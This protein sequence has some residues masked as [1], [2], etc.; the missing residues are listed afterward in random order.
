MI[1]ETIIITGAGRGIGKAIALDLAK[2]GSFIVCISRTKTCKDTTDEILKNG[3]KSEAIILDVSD[4]E[5]TEKIVQEYLNKTNHNNI[6]LVLA[7]GIIGPIGPINDINLSEWDSCHRVNVL[8]SLAII[9][10]CL[11]MML[12]DK[13]GK[14][15]TFAGGGAAYANPVFPAYSA[16][17]TAMVRITENI[18]EDLKDKGDFSIICLGPGAIETDMLKQVKSAGGKIKTLSHISE[19]I[20]LVR[21]FMES[22]KCN[23]SGC[24][25]HVRNNWKDYLDSDKKISDSFW[26]LRRIE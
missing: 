18:N 5:Y 9:K 6:G 7:A 15:V 3:G 11:P 24:F 21:S 13:F 23:F 1:P 16:T 10:A 19:P 4:Y 2:K 12:K 8:G 25:V 26:K 14:I 20:T 17:K 22:E